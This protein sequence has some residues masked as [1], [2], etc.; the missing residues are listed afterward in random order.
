MGKTCAICGKQGYKFY[1]LCY[2]HLQMKADG[3]VVKCE[4]CGSWHFADQACATCGEGDALT[5][6]TVVEETC[7]KTNSENTQQEAEQKLKSERIALFAAKIATD[8]YFVE[9]I[10]INTKTK[11]YLLKL[12]SVQNLKF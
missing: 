12:P 10:I 3:K 7:K 11:H 2:E 4:E 8:I 9:T 1:P 5:H 6:K